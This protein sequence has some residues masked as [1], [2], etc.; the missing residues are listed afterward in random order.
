MT[1]KQNSTM[2]DKYRLKNLFEE[3]SKPSTPVTKT[4]NVRKKSKR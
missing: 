3:V 2:P 1:L 4:I